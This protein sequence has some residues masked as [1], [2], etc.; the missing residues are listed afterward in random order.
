[1]DSRVKATY[2]FAMSIFVCTTRGDDEHQFSL[3][4]R[5]GGVLL[6]SEGYSS[7]SG[8]DHGIRSVQE[9]SIYYRRY[10]TRRSKD[11]RYFFNMKA[12]NGQVIGTSRMYRTPGTRDAAINT[13]VEGARTA[14]VG[15]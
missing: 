7:K 13:I 4:T 6:S 11:N 3:Q 5:D 2:I 15:S 14:Q 1:M 8:R 12:R 9:N 10:E